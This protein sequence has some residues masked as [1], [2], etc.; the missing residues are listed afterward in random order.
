MTTKK[1]RK[2]RSNTK[3]AA[4]RAYMKRRP[5]AGPTE[6]ARALTKKGIAISAAH[7]SNVKAYNKRAAEANGEAHQAN[8]EAA[9]TSGR[10]PGRRG[11]KPAPRDVVSLGALL[12][13]RKFAE[14]VG[15]VDKASELLDAL[16]KLQ[17]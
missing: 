9:S 16:A 7:V 8:G 1:P 11:R 15:G 13:A 10:K 5:E 4:I 6:I 14:R 3:A 2:K 12:E 17:G